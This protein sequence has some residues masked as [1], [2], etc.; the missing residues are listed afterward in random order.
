MKKIEHILISAI[1]AIIFL[2]AV[3]A[4]CTFFPKEMLA[5]FAVFCTIACVWYAYLIL[6]DIFHW[7]D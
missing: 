1:V 7:E 5:I 6:S 3:I 4:L 2:G